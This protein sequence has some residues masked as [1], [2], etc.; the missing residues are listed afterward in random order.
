MSRLE[1]ALTAPPADFEGNFFQKTCDCFFEEY[2]MDDYCNKVMRLLLLEHFRNPEI[3]KLYDDWMFERPLH[4]QAEIFF[5]LHA[6]GIIKTADS[7]YLAV[8]FYAPVFLFMQRWLFCGPLTEECKQ[9]FRQNAYE[10]IHHFFKE[11]EDY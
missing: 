11:T 10:H 3:Q 1:Q 9:H 8:K 2:L 4:F 6:L 7:R 5:L